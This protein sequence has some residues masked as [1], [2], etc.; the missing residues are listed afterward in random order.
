MD[1]F[2]ELFIIFFPYVFLFVDGAKEG[3]WETCLV[4][5]FFF[6]IEQEDQSF[7]FIL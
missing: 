1:L 4:V 5:V 6:Y 3:E 2:L 7:V